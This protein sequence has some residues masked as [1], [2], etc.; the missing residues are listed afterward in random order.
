MDD[1]PQRQ[2]GGPGRFI[3]FEGPDG[4]GKSTHA[5]LLAGRL[6]ALLTREPGGTSLGRRLRDLV[7][8]PATADLGDRA[9][10]LLMAADRAQ[11]VAEVIR[12]TL[13]RGRH[14]VAD[15]YLYSSVAYQGY[16]RG[17]DPAEVEAL[18]TWAT[19]ALLPDLVI[20]LDAPQGLLNERRCVHP[21]RLEALGEDFHRRVRAGYRAQAGA[22]PHRWV[23]IDA[24]G[25]AEH[26][27]RAVLEA[28]EDRL[29]FAPLASPP[30]TP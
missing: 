21:D 8:D 27:S 22:Q 6:G 3:V 18:S 23:L 5:A 15:R 25:D 26:T 2:V 1:A 7:L 12:P 14:V 30:E 28:V 24:G 13:L 19:A 9:E 10:A 17:L 11:H 4:V 16:G 20:L 29:G